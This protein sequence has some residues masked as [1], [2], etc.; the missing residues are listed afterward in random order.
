MFARLQ[1]LLFSASRDRSPAA[2]GVV[3]TKAE[4]ILWAVKWQSHNELDG[5]RS[6]FMN[7]N[8]VPVL[9]TKRA[10]ARAW[11]KQTHGYVA[12]RPDLRAEPHGWLVP[13]PVRVRVSLVEDA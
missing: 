2:G 10:A 1:A 12:N 6:H 4:R 13:R 5:Y 11:V 3:R 7:E 8:C 9:F